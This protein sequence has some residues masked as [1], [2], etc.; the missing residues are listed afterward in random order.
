MQ[1]SWGD[2]WNGA[3]VDVSV[4]GTVVVANWGL[5][6]GSAGSDS[7]ATINGDVVDFIFN[8]GTY[9]NEVTFQITDPTGFRSYGPSPATG[10][11]LTDTSAAICQ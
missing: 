3:S 5:A 7:I 2:G 1:D 9:D 10:L 6:S 8:S 4:N 11:F